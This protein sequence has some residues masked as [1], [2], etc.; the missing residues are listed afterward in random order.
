MLFI[1][2]K[3][4]TCKLVHII[5]FYVYYKNRVKGAYNTAYSKYV[6][7]LLSLITIWNSLICKCG[8]EVFRFKWDVGVWCC[9]EHYLTYPGF[10]HSFLNTPVSIT[11]RICGITTGYI[12]ILNELS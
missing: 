1:E 6:F 9:I 5:A 8:V 7:V 4:K 11:I 12:E 2:S 3:K 10:A